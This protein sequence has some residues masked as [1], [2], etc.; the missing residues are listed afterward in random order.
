MEGAC[1]LCRSK[2]VKILAVEERAGIAYRV[3]DC[4]NCRVVQ[5]LDVPDALSPDYVN[6][7]DTEIEQDRLWCQGEHKLAAYAQWAR[8]MA[9]LGIAVEGARLLDVGCGTGG[10]LDHVRALG[11]KGQGFDASVAQARAARERGLDAQAATSPSA[12]HATLSDKSGFDI[13]TLWDVFE[14]LREPMSFLAELKPL[15]KHGGAL[16]I[17][18]PNGGALGWKRTLWELAGRKFSYE[19]WEHVFYYRPESLRAYLEQ[20]G[21]VGIEVGSVVAYER[22]PS[23]GEFVR[24]AAFRATSLTPAI[25]PQIY[26]VARRP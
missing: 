2:E 9:R 1:R 16:F 6:L 12:Y 4:L 11:A 13:V 5:A 3:A 17:S 18:I 20:A 22:K 26:A 10:F 24:R 19:P 14:H 23:A 8:T 25:N 7:A 21:Y 15:M